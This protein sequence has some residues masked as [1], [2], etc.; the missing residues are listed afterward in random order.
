MVVK[1]PAGWTAAAAGPPDARPRPRQTGAMST[2]KDFSATTIDGTQQDLGEYAGQV[3]LV[4]NTASECGLTPQYEGLEQL[5]QQYAC[6]LY[7]SP[8]PRD[9]G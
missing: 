5:H 2:L 6:L 7:T 4:V 9:R 3:V 8:S 1:L